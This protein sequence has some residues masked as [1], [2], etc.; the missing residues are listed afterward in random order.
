MES[1]EEYLKNCEL[2]LEDESI[3]PCGI[4]LESVTLEFSLPYPG[5]DPY[6]VTIYNDVAN[7]RCIISSKEK[8]RNLLQGDIDIMME[9]S[10]V[11]SGVCFGHYEEVDE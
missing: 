8:D 3:I 7:N 9:A 11:I 6:K 10:K 1:V 5:S 4:T 2:M